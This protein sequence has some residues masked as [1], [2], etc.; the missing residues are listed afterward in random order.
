MKKNQDNYVESLYKKARR[1]IF[2]IPAIILVALLVGMYS[3]YCLCNSASFGEFISNFVKGSIQFILCLDFLYLVIGVPIY[4]LIKYFIRRNFKDM[5]IEMNDKDSIHYF[6]ECLDLPISIVGILYN[7]ELTDSHIVSILLSLEHRGYIDC[8]KE[9]VEIIKKDISNLSV[10]EQT[11]LTL[12]ESSSS[13]GYFKKDLREWLLAE[14]YRLGYLKKFDGLINKTLWLSWILFFVT[15]LLFDNLDNPYNHYDVNYDI[16]EAIYSLFS[17]VCFISLISG[18]ISL[19]AYLG[20]KRLRYIRSKNGQ[21][22]LSKI[23]ALERYIKDFGDLDDL[24]A[25]ALSFR[26]DFYLYSVLFGDNEDVTKEYCN[27]LINMFEQK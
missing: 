13:Y 4:L 3:L 14:A 22:I 5:E 21:D 19:I 11:F 10:S 6:R 24:P 12:L 2:G 8:S 18:V 9:C 27:K 23:S 16:F 15:I 1:I 20:R 26:G 25:E 7:Y 17:I